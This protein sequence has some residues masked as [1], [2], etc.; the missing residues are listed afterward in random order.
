MGVL[1]LLDSLS[2]AA[3]VGVRA[4]PYALSLFA[5]MLMVGCGPIARYHKERMEPVPIP[6][7]SVQDACNFVAQQD[8]K[9]REKTLL[10]QQGDGVLKAF[11]DECLAAPPE[12]R[13]LEVKRQLELFLFIGETLP[14]GWFKKTTIRD[15]PDKL[16]NPHIEVTARSPQLEQASSPN[17]FGTISGPGQRAI[18][19]YL[20]GKGNDLDALQKLLS[21]LR[22]SSGGT[23]SPSNLEARQQVPLLISTSFN[24]NNPADRLER[25]YIFL[26]PLQDTK[27]V[28]VDKLVLETVK[29]NVTLG[30]EVTTQEVSPTFSIENLLVGDDAKGKGGLASSKFGRTLDKTL[31]KQFALR[32]VSLDP[33]RDILFVRQ[34]G[35]EGID[36][37]GNVLSTITLETSPSPTVLDLFSVEFQPASQTGSS[38]PVGVIKRSQEP[39]HNIG[40]ID[41]TVAWVAVARLVEGGSETVSEEDDV[42][43]PKVFSGQ[44]KVNLWR[45]NKQFTFLFLEHKV[46]ANC[47]YV[48]LVYYD[49]FER[50]ARRMAFRSQAEARRFKE[51]IIRSNEKLARDSDLQRILLKIDADNIGIGFPIGRS[52]EVDEKSVNLTW[53]GQEGDE[54]K[55]LSALR[56]GVTEPSDFPMTK[57]Q[58]ETTCPTK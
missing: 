6:E 54:L 20:K 11:V 1:S 12:K 48:P 2:L 5:A 41:A 40:S 43:Q 50:R 14:R 9:I 7:F 44:F 55:N 18:V 38:T 47:Y 49:V 33:Q 17:F 35:Q 13:R 27:I 19:D 28:D 22:G 10:L 45:N 8:P 37:S 15:E 29:V 52:G 39:F 34:E 46:G 57:L 3:A 24:S 25:V 56:V 58:V 23:S 16:R 31:T 26:Q 32:S 36:I 4:R 30:K 21:T 42:V 51:H 53:K